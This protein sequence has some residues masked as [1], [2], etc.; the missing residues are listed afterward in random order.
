MGNP[1]AVAGKLASGGLNNSSPNSGTITKG[2]INPAAEVG[3]K[4]PADTQT[5]RLL[6][7]CIRTFALNSVVTSTHCACTHIDL[8]EKSVLAG[9]HF[10][11]CFASSVQDLKKNLCAQKLVSFFLPNVSGEL[12]DKPASLYSISLSRHDC[13]HAIKCSSVH[14]FLNN[15]SLPPQKN[16]V[17]IYR[18]NTSAFLIKGVIFDFQWELGSLLPPCDFEN[19][20]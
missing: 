20:S 7:G 14:F 6:L 1:K 5:F 11:T 17:I 13:N 12:V 8:R 16:N 15:P 3:G 10:Q 9:L 18:G 4:I 2:D 19:V